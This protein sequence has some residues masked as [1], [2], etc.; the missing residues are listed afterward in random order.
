M[1]AISTPLHFFQVGILAVG[2]G[3]SELDPDSGRSRTFMRSTLS[4]DRRFVD[5]ACAAEFMDALRTVIERPEYMNLGF[6]PVLR[7][8]RNSST[9]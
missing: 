8:R 1:V 4:F 5:E 6:V 9:S 2:S 7:A 3:V